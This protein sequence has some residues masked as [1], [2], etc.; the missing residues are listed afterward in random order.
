MPLFH[1]YI[2]VAPRDQSCQAS[3]GK[4]LT[5]DSPWQADLS[6]WPSRNWHKFLM[7]AED[8]WK[9]CPGLPFSNEIPSGA[10]AG[11]WNNLCR[12]HRKEGQPSGAKSGSHG[13]KQQSCPHGQV[14][15]EENKISRM[16]EVSARYLKITAWFLR[17]YLNWFPSPAKSPITN[18][19]LG[20]ALLTR[21]NGS[22]LSSWAGNVLKC[23]QCRRCE[24][25]RHR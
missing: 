1:I 16:G 23:E 24:G 10:P 25:R 13:T 18:E 21:P 14:G 5:N 22:R 6:L 11:L 15:S 8:G 7:F 20:A 4:L 17:V 9:S 12:R 3:F 2:V 19:E